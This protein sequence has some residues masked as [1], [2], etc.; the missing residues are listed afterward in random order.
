MQSLERLCEHRLHLLLGER[1][2]APREQN[3]KKA[4]H[5][6]PLELHRER[7]GECDAREHLLIAARLF[8]DE[9]GELYL[10]DPDALNGDA[11]RVG[12]ALYVEH[13]RTPAA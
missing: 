7:D 13:H 6:R 12:A 11:A 1:F 4:A 9:E 10:L 3:L 2:L 5:M 8:L